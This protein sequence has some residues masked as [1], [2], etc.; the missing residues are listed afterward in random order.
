MKNNISEIVNIGNVYNRN[1][2]EKEKNSKRSKWKKN[3]KHEKEGVNK[4][5][6]NIN[7]LK[8]N[9]QKLYEYRYIIN[10]VLGNSNMESESNICINKINYNDMSKPLRENELREVLNSFKV[11]PPKEDLRNIWI[12]TIGIAKEGLDVIQKELK[13]SIQ[14]Y[15]DN[16]FLDRIEHSSHRV[17]AYDYIFKRHILK[18]FQEVTSEEL[19][20]FK[21]FLVLIDNKHTLYYILKFIYSFL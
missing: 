16:D 10:N 5:K 6:S 2:G 14:K 17:F 12:H 20:S 11:C 3:L 7:D 8:C 15:L 9:E 21:R 4:T 1:L 18:N 19:L 13:A